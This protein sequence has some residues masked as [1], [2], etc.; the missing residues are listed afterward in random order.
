MKTMKTMESTKTMEPMRTM[1]AT[2]RTLATVLSF[3]LVGP[4][5]LYGQGVEVRGQACESGVLVGSLG[6]SGLD[7][8]GECSVTMSRAGKEESW[9]F[10]TEPR[11]FSIE[12]G[13]AASGILRAGDYLVA[14]D[15]LLITTREGGR[16]YANLVPG[17]V[18]TV[19]YRREGSLQEAGIRVGAR[20]TLPPPP[21][22]S[23]GRVAVPAPPVEPARG[24]ARVG[25]ARAPRV[26]VL[27]SPA[28]PD[29]VLPVV[30]TAILSTGVL[31]DP[32]PRGRLGIGLQCERCGTEIDDETGK[33][34][35]FFSGP[36]EVT[37]VDPD[38][39]AEKAGI[40]MGDLIS[41]IDGHD[42]ST[43]A[44]GL[45]FSNLTP[46][47]PV[48]VTVVRRNGRTEDVTVVPGEARSGLLR[49]RVGLAGVSEPVEPAPP[50]VGAAV[51]AP[52]ARPAGGVARVEPMATAMVGPEELPLSYSGTVAGVEVVVRGGPVA[53]SE[54]QGART[55]IINADGLWVRIRVP[56]GGRDEP[57][58]V[59]R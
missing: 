56:A 53:V 3:G 28:E 18:V 13:G 50:T 11:I 55:I 10:S 4:I 51:A 1:K 22:A 5:P 7:C 29:S 12:P 42:I 41:A 35:W 43:E 49:G 39:A 9:V 30:P 34:V 14:I 44:G 32:T 45:A 38:G 48:R 52:P 16:R 31:L 59:R 15:G 37:G 25:I 26:R 23:V 17:E 19:R 47:E 6:I 57:P 20:C 21:A 27:P 24:V 58:P 8:V 54:L 46:G 2:T 36:I 33:S 40:Q